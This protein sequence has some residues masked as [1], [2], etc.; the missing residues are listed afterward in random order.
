MVDRR[1]DGQFNSRS[2]GPRNHISATS[3]VHKMEMEDKQG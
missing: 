2:R 1:D 3:T